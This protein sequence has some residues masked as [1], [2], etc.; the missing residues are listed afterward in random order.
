MRKYLAILCFMLL[1]LTGCTI[2]VYHNCDYFMVFEASI[3]DS[4]GVE[5]SYGYCSECGEM[6]AYIDGVEQGN[7]NA[8]V[9]RVKELQQYRLEDN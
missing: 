1:L 7:K 4:A 5:Y 2:H 8:V 3:K 6:L 9:K